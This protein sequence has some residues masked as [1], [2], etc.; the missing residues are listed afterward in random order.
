MSCLQSQ[1]SLPVLITFILER[2]PCFY[3]LKTILKG[4]TPYSSLFLLS[5]FDREKILYY[6]IYLY[7]IFHLKTSPVSISQFLFLFLSPLGDDSPHSDKYYYYLEEK[8]YN[9]FF[10]N[11]FCSFILELND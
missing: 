2:I 10:Q 1:T 4:S 9:Y 7:H 11:P 5:R 8:V 6:C 3:F